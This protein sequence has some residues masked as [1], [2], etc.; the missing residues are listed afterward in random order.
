M[1]LVEISHFAS[2]EHL[3]KDVQTVL[4]QG[5]H[6]KSL[7]FNQFMGLVGT[8][9]NFEQALQAMSEGSID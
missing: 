5:H 7:N 4:S 3:H 2:I 1:N 8:K 9:W 6:V